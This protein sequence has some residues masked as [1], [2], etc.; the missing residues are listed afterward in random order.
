MSLLNVCDIHS[1]QIIKS[2]E[3]I[4]NQFSTACAPC[5]TDHTITFTALQQ[6]N[7]N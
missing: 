7:L 5:P 2:F 4:F 6:E 3:Y 1:D